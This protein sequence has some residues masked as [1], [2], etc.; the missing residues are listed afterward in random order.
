ME[1]V[2]R[3]AAARLRARLG[4][5]VF[6]PAV[7]GWLANQREPPRL[8]VACSG[9]ADS[10]AL[11]VLLADRYAG[12]PEM[13]RVAHFNHRWRG[14]ASDRDADF[15]TFLAAGLGLS[16]VT[17]RRP[18][19]VEAFT[20]TTARL[21]RL[22]FLRQAAAE[23]DA[24][25]IAFGHQRD[26]IL[27]TQLQRLAR[28]SGAEGLSAPRPVQGFADGPVHLHPL[29]HHPATALRAA[30]EACGISWR[31]DATN[32]DTAVARNALRHSVIPL[33]ADA[34]DRDPGTGAFRSRR[35]LEE[36][37]SA[38]DRWAREAAPEAFA[39]ANSLSRPRLRELPRAVVRRAL[40]AWLGA[41]GVLDHLSAS[42][43]DALVETAA[44][45]SGGGRH[46][47]GEGFIVF[48]R[49]RIEFQA[50]PANE[51]PGPE[52]RAFRAGER[53]ELPGGA[54]VTAALVALD[55][56]SRAHILAGKVDCAT[57]AFLALH[58]PGERLVL[59]G[60]RAGDR[61]HPLG[62][63]GSR[64]LQDW[65]TDRRVPPRERGRLPVVLNHEGFVLWVPGLAPAE[66]RRVEPS[67]ERALRLTYR[68]PDP[69]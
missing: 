9:G 69:R 16:C 48:N 38:L 2:T 15:V 23:F 17:D 60:W 58:D 55:D 20:E 39:G 42:A 44:D 50:R 64:K 45:A 32:A 3:E 21:L 51:P 63:P 31:E 66:A 4:D 37:A 56:A 35:L 52:E 67:T 26:D 22:D 27:E 6:D 25:G 36:D 43:I 11:L 30:L 34:L 57:T 8:L 54:A 12:S 28:G 13:L 40:L 7:D 59:R 61:F 41:Q 65:F 14:A 1:Q 10:T 33:L 62:A 19:G 49:D 46:S 53:I 18:D 5:P 47:A 24:A 29:L 68:A